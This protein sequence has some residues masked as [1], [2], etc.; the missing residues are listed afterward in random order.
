MS[1]LNVNDSMSEPVEYLRESLSVQWRAVFAGVIISTLAYLIL[2]SLGVALGAAQ[3]KDWMGGDVDVQTLGTGAGVYLLL[4]VLISL[5][6]GSYSSARVS[7]VIA[8]RIGYTQGAV[9]AALFFTLMISQAGVAIGALGSSLGSLGGVVGGAAGQALQSQRLNSVVE[10]AVSDLRLKTSPREVATGVL[11]RVMRGDS[12][13]AI[14]YLASQSGISRDAAAARFNR[15]NDQLRASAATMAI[16]G[17]DA[18][19]KAGWAAFA[20]LLVGVV[21]AV[22]GGALGAQ[23]SIRAP[24]GAMDQRALR[25]AYS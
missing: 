9:I 14:N 10:D 17:A 20:T 11:A 15:V 2:M 12:E 3:L 23:L 16:K 19:Q 13:S 22:L 1:D 4:S 6:V 7:G 8:T 18:A 25:T 5:F 21:G 24:I